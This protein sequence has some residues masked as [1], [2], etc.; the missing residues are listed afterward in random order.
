MNSSAVS[1]VRSLVSN[2]QFSKSGLPLLRLAQEDEVSQVPRESGTWI[3]KSAILLT[4]LGTSL[5]IFSARQLHDGCSS[6][7][8]RKK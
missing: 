1:K 3:A 5:S 6:K 7:S 4:L 2:R 8:F